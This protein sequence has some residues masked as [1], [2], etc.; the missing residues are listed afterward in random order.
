MCH[1]RSLL[2][3]TVFQLGRVGAVRVHE[4]EAEDDPGPGRQTRT[5]A[6]RRTRK[7]HRFLS[8]FIFPT[9]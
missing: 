6:D 2:F 3:L 1:A 8:R 5:D 4:D 9:D 7:R